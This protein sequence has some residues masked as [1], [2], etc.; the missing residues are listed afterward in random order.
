MTQVRTPQSQDAPTLQAT[1]VA[2]NAKGGDASVTINVKN[3]FDSDPEFE[4]A[5]TNTSEEA[6]LL[7]VDI[8]PLITKA[9]A[10]V[11]NLTYGSTV[12]NRTATTQ[13]LRRINFMATSIAFQ[14]SNVANY[15]GNLIFGELKYDGQTKQKNV[16]L[17][18]YRE[19]NGNGYTD[20]AEV[21]NEP[22]VNNG[23]SFIVLSK[24]KA[25]STM[26]FRFGIAMDSKAPTLAP[27]M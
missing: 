23:Y 3:N 17:S 13:F 18:K 26:Y 5:V 4:I 9:I 19:T 2:T 10:E 8:I 16:R 21:K 7:N 6:D 24:L 12:G 11:A 22:F 25:N 1:G 20:V 14:T 27:T 15:E